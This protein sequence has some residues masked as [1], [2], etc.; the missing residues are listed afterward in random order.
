LPKKLI[1]GVPKDDLK[2][3]FEAKKSII[4]NK[5]PHWLPSF[6]GRA[7]KLDFPALRKNNF[8]ACFTEKQI[9]GPK[10]NLKSIFEAEKLIK[11]RFWTQKI[12]KV[13]RLI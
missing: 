5:K 6:K 3:D 4:V 8:A 11:S 1:L 7:S 12:L 13:E 10:R 2:V 9:F